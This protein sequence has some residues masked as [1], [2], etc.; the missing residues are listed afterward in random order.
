VELPFSLQ[1]HQVLEAVKSN[2]PVLKMLV[3]LPLNYL[4]GLSACE[5]FVANT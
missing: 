2:K 1:H 3:Y 5:C 4:V